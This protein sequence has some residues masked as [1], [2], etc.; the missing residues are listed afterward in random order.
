M[1]LL[2]VLMASIDSWRLDKK[3]SI[4]QSTISESLYFQCNLEP[5]P[6]FHSRSIC[7]VKYNILL[8]PSSLE[9]VMSQDFV[10]LG[11]IFGCRDLILEFISIS[12]I[13]II[14]EASSVNASMEKD[15]ESLEKSDDFEWTAAAIVQSVALFGLAGVAEILGGWMVWMALRGNSAGK[16]P[17]WY[18]LLG[19]LVLVAYGFIPCFQPT[20]NFGRIYAAYGGFFILLCFLFGWALDGNRPDVGDIVGGMISLVGVLLIMFWPR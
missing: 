15:T 13:D 1:L 14:M 12:I 11:E 5:Q 2:V 17:W 3:E 16:K 18:G 6:H 4:V 10:L 19:S 9:K 20:N 7:N 8:V